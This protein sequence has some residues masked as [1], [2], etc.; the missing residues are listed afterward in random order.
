MLIQ[1]SSTLQLEKVHEFLLE[2][3]DTEGIN[4]LHNFKNNT[5]MFK[6]LNDKSVI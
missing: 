2:N 4:S 5:E 6:T 3:L 1:D